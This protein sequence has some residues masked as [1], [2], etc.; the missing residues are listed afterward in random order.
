MPDDVDLLTALRLMRM[1]RALL[2]RAGAGTAATQLSG[3]IDAVAR[4]Q[5]VSRGSAAGA[6]ASP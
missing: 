4:E 6:D 5:P 2:E 3:A 1:A